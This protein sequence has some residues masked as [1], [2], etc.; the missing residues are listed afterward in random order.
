L[1]AAGD[2]AGS[3]EERLRESE[4]RFRQFAENSA[5]IVW[6]AD[7]ATLRLEY[8]SPAFEEV[9]GEARDAMMQ[10]IRRWNA[11]VHPEDRERVIASAMNMLQGQPYVQEYRIIRPADGDI[12]WIRGTGFPMPDDDGTLRRLGGIAQDITE[13]K[14]V[15]ERE[16][17]LWGELQ[18]RV[19]N[20]LAEVRSIAARTVETNKDPDEFFIHF[21]GRL[22]ALARTHSILTRGDD[23]AADLEE[24]VRDEF[25][26]AAIEDDRIEVAGPPVRLKDGAAQVIALAIH[27]LATNAVKFGALAVPAGGVSVQWRVASGGGALLL[28]WRESGVPAIDPAPRRAGFGRELI[29]RGLAYEL[30]ARTSLQFIGGGVLVAIELPLDG[31]KVVLDTEVGEPT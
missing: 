25:L 13:A 12:R 11:L 16:R 5:S 3:A 15:E 27:E 6:I 14:R 24:L 31:K 1:Q 7:V 19:R 4:K 26:A 17:R 21:D 18:L 23:T 22:A 29:E 8:L 20:I 2:T 9:A 10:D 28:E 30:G